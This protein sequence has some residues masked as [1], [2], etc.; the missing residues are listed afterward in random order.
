MVVT[1][2]HM[3]MTPAECASIQ[4]ITPPVIVAA[5]PI[6]TVWLLS[7]HDV[8]AKK[9]QLSAGLVGSVNFRYYYGFSGD[10]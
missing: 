6:S 4:P 5:Q 2:M 3:A 9:N 10:S 1:I 8:Q 7:I